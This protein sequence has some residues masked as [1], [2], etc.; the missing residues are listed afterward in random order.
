MNIFA[1]Q[2]GKAKQESDV[3]LWNVTAQVLGRMND[4]Q[5][6]QVLT[7]ALSSGH[8]AFI[9]ATAMRIEQIDSP[10]AVH[11]LHSK[12]QTENNSQR[13]TIMIKAL[14]NIGNAKRQ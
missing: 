3:D 12:L 7:D 5:A 10:Q 1:I 4:L 11:M 2:D 9:D 13:Q 14:T 6:I 8:P